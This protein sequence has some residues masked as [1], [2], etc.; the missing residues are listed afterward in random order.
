MLHQEEDHCRE[1]K[2]EQHTDLILIL[3]FYLFN[4]YSESQLYSL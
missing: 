4:Y 1:K 3:F 2:K